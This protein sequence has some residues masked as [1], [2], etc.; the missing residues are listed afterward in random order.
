MILE[1]NKNL[2]IQEA[3]ELLE[4]IKKADFIKRSKANDKQ[5]ERLTKKAKEFKNKTTFGVMKDEAKKGL[6]HKG[7]WGAIKAGTAGFRDSKYHKEFASQVGN[8]MEKN[9]RKA[10]K[11]IES[12]MDVFKEAKQ[13]TV[14]KAYDAATAEN[15][16]RDQRAKKEATNAKRRATNQANKQRKQEEEEEAAAAAAAEKASSATK[17][18]S[19]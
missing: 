9:N 12:N 8:Q 19:R 7:I 4:E 1:I 14:N 18:R 5:K 15:K 11:R 16:E 10:F 6:K 2:L 3:T 17:K 13:N